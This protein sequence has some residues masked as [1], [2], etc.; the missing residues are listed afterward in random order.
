[1]QK[2]DVYGQKYATTASDQHKQKQIELLEPE[3]QFPGC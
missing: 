2:N 1:M 3:I